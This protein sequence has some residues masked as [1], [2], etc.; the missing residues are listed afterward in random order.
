VVVYRRLMVNIAQELAGANKCWAL[1]SGDSLGQVASQTAGN[2]TVVDEAAT[3]PFLRPLIGMD[4]LE[5]MQQAQ[6]IGTYDI[7]IEADQDCCRLFIPPNPSTR[8]NLGMVRK[9]EA[10]LDFPGLVKQ[11]LEKVEL[12]EF[13]FP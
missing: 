13:R 5:I 11:A 4:K 8:A 9:T 10:Q 2:I 7:S 1:V 12:R 6:Q 3:L